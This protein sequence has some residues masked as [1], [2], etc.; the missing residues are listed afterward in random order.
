M[1]DLTSGLILGIIYVA[2]PGPISIETLRQGIKGGFLTSLAVQAGSSIGLVLY[3]LLALFGADWLLQELEWQL[4]VGVCGVLVLFYL[5]ITTIRDGRTLASAMNQ[6]VPERRSARNAF[7][8]GAVLS[9]A[10][11]L[12]II[13]W[14][15]LS[16]HVV[17]DP[18]LNGPVFLSS[19]FAGCVIASLVVV[20]FAGLWQ[21]RLPLKATLVLCWVCGLALI[22][23][24]L[25]LGVSVGQQLM[26]LGV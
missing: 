19:F 3:A 11:P 16:S 25:K 20:A 6:R 2:T 26:I 15:S 14:L 10:N 24:G 5:G 17:H 12:E 22:G 1:M 21:A 9:L 18:A 8:M 4:I 7:R 23:F 13:F